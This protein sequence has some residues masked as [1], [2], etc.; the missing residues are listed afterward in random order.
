ML[1]NPFALEGVK[2]LLSPVI[3]MNFSSIEI[4]SKGVRLFKPFIRK[5]SNPFVMS[6]SEYPFH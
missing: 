3:S 4:T 5:A 1:R 2:L 6:A